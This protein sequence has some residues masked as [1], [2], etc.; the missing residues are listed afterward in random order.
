MNLDT[1][2]SELENRTSDIEQDVLILTDSLVATD[3][4]ILD[5]EEIHLGTIM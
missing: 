5:L 1:D 2:T 4:R 3:L